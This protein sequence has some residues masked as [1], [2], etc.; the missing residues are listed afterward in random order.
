MSGEP[1]L[2]FAGFVQKLADAAGEI[3]R[4]AYT[5]PKSFV[6]KPDSSPVTQWDRSVERVIRGMILSEYPGHGI[7]GEEDGKYNTD[8]EWCWV[9]DPI[10][11]TKAFIAGIPVFG[12]LI[13]LARNRTP[14]LGVID[15]P[16]SRDRWI[17]CDG[18][19]ATLNGKPIHVRGC[20]DLS[21]AL[22]F[23]S[24]PESF[25]GKL[26]SGFDRLREN[27]KWAVYGGS[28]HAYGMLATGALDIGVDA[29]FDPPDFCALVPVI[30]NA[31][32]ISSDWSGKPLTLDSDGRFLAAGDA[33]LHSLAL[34]YLIETSADVSG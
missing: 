33:R 25:S 20:A 1:L 8:A 32:G 13:A 17:G 6:T 3:I 23:T 27:V 2:E 4:R 9:I 5:C 29:G 18:S 24:S 19:P 21:D 15:N 30:R 7:W 14:V 34:G 31:G 22:L 10:D 26:K 11:G 16:V 12:V 28:C